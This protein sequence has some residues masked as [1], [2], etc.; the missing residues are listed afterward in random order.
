MVRSALSGV[1]F[2]DLIAVYLDEFGTTSSRSKL[3]TI[4]HIS[5]LLGRTPLPDLSVSRFREFAA[6][7]R[8]EGAGPSTVGQDLTYIHTILK[9]GGP[10]LDVD[11]SSALGAYA[12][13]RAILSASGGVARP[14]ER[15][16]RPTDGEHWSSCA[17]NGHSAAVWCLCGASHSLQS[18]RQCA[19]RR[20]AASVG[21]IWTWKAVW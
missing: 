21:M 18:A 20:Y 6:Q 1:V 9:H 8:A 19:C 3:G 11:T 17:I 4:T 5:E 2:N 7:R 16:R 12:S 10:L 15:T 14:K 13:A